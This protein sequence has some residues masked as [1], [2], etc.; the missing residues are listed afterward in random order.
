MNVVYCLCG[1]GVEVGIFG[2]FSVV[3]C[4]SCSGVC[5]DKY[6]SWCYC[7]MISCGVV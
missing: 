4:D 6:Y 1:V 2:F 3:I 5:I 7:V